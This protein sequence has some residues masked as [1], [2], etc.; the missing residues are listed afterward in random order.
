MRTYLVQHGEATSEEE[1]PDRP[2]TDEGRSG[3]MGVIQALRNSGGVA[4]AEIY[5]SGKT[6]ARQTAEI[7]ADGLAASTEPEEADGLQPLDDPAEWAE[8]LRDSGRDT[9]LVGHLP[10]MERMAGLLLVDDPEAEVVS[11]RYGGVVC[12]EDD[13]GGWSLAWAVTPDAVGNAI[14]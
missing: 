12:L 3:L 11:F 1:D 14:G 5:H 6:R 2:L 7:L 8:R 13:G 10:Y 4:P 9:M